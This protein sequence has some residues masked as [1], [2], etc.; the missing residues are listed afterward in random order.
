MTV[1]DKFQGRNQIG[2]NTLSVGSTCH[3]VSHTQFSSGL[4]NSI[5][6]SGIS[7]ISSHVLRK[8]SRRLH[9]QLQFFE[10]QQR[11]QKLDVRGNHLRNIRRSEHCVAAD[12]FSK[13]LELAEH[14]GA[15]LRKK[16]GNGELSTK[17]LGSSCRELSVLW[18]WFRVRDEPSTGSAYLF[19]THRQ[20]IITPWHNKSRTFICVAC[21]QRVR[22]LPLNRQDFIRS[23]WDYLDVP[24]RDGHELRQLEV[25]GDSS[26]D[27][28]SHV[29]QFTCKWSFT[30]WRTIK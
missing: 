23:S 22:H 1:Y 6:R 12:Q 18:R 9:S 15:D 21:E 8:H 30:L 5:S 17:L 3:R 14:E 10:R 28:S 7:S 19:R 29:Q 26:R 25:E 11:L 27:W 16:R 20:T 4:R 2:R 13:R 24:I